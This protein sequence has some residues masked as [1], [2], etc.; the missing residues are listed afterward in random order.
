MSNALEKDSPHQKGLSLAK[1][2]PAATLFAIVISVVFNIGYFSFIDIQLI[3]LLSYTDFLKSSI[4]GIPLVAMMI[5]ILYIYNHF[6][7]LP[8]KLI[9]N[10]QSAEDT[11]AFDKTE[12]SKKIKYSKHWPFYLLALVFYFALSMLIISYLSLKLFTTII[13]ISFL[14]AIFLLFIIRCFIN[15]KSISQRE[16]IQ[17]IIIP[18]LILASFV[19]GI[20]N[21]VLDSHTRSRDGIIFTEKNGK[22]EIKILRLIDSG[23]IYLKKDEKNVIYTPWSQIFTF[24]IA[25]NK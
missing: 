17:Y 24:E 12:L 23:L 18:I 5:F 20:L 8:Y 4:L 14:I 3:H 21:G 22:L 15:E 7:I 2:A 11:F 10:S 13:F 9:S 6:S 1:Y 19:S 25:F 16:L